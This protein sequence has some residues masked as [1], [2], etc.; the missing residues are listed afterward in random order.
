LG[1]KDYDIYDY[2]DISISRAGQDVRYALDDSK[3]RSIGWE[4]KKEF[5]KEISPIIAYY[6]DNFIW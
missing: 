5:D 1:T 6:K 3:L 4:P 2:I